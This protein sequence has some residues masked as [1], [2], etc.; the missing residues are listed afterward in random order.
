MAEDKGSTSGIAGWIK[1]GVTSAFG[2]VSGAV[3]MY[4]TPLVNTVI[5]PAKPVA[6]FAA[7]V[8]GLSVT[9]NNRSLG[10]TQGWWDFG[11]GSALEPFSAKQ[12]TITHTYAQAGSYTVKLSLQNLLGEENV[13]DSSIHIDVNST[14]KPI[15][16]QFQVT[17]EKTN[18]TNAAGKLVA[19]AVFRIEAKLENAQL[20]VWGLG[21]SRKL[22]VSTDTA[23]TQDRLVTLTHPGSH[24]LRLVAVNGKET[25]E[26]SQEVIV[27]AAEQSAVE[28]PR[29]RLRVTY[30]AMQVGRFSQQRNVAVAWTAGH[31]ESTCPF[32]GTFLL[33]SAHQDCQIVAAEVLNKQDPHVR[34]VRVEVAPDKG[35]FVLRGELVHSAK[36]WDLHKQSPPP[37]VAQVALQ[38]ERRSTPQDVPMEEIPVNLVVPGTT[39]IPIP[40]LSSGWQMTGKRLHLELCDGSK[41]VWSGDQP[42]SRTALQLGHRPVIVSAV[43]QGDRL[44]LQVNDTAPGRP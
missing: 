29:A 31:K 26:K 25:V 21:G 2:L 18:Q 30:A 41:I 3:L 10:G 14:P 20:C 40:H 19:P 11:D 4:L 23:A 39:A 8:Q 15:I 24:I 13:R 12:E 28:C 7:Q 36:W 1:A 32:E 33:D 27:A 16:T 17:P 22:E 42:P 9:F 37:W 43:E 35:R 6:N 5:K 38:L 44:I 34:N